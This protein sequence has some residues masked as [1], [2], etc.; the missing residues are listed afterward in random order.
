M[1]P[2]SKQH[3]R[4]LHSNTILVGL[5]WRILLISSPSFA[6][7]FGHSA[8]KVSPSD[9]DTAHTKFQEIA[10]AY[11]ILS[12]PT[13]RERYDTTGS[14][15]ES[16]SDD[17][18]WASF[19]KAQYAET[20]TVDKMNE[21]KATYQ[22]SDEEKRDVLDAYKRR[23][24]NVDKIFKDVML[25]NAL[26]DEE[27]FRQ[28][29]DSAV[30]AGELESFNAYTQESENAKKKRKKVAKREEAEAKEHA[31]ELGVYESLFGDGKP[32]SKKDNGLASLI[33]QRQKERAATFLDDL[34]AKYAGKGPANGKSK[35]K[36]RK[37]S[38]D[39]VPETN[40]SKQKRRKAAKAVVE[41]DEEDEQDA[42]MDEPPEEAFQAVAAR[43][44]K[45]GKASAPEDDS[46]AVESLGTE[47]SDEEDE[48]EEE[49]EVESE[50]SEEEVKP[51]PKAKGKPQP[52]KGSK[53]YPTAKAKPITRASRGKK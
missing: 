22:G 21:F 9:R 24:G 6:H 25:S 3:T 2:R 1:K 41:S 10:F 33:Q 31:K 50:E 15:S 34:E 36:K 53:A 32:K 46:D 12:E 5:C 45:S 51:P 40:G 39:E 23:K 16:L 26:Y 47:D 37:S 29:I 20:V 4:S 49:A 38:D 43:T 14:T 8:D 48:E 35:T 52:K 17:F 30:A 11:A 28:Y 42:A 18:N 19:F 13:R 44:Q 27:R 7:T